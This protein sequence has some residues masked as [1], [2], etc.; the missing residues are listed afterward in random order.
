[1]SRR[2]RISVEDIQAEAEEPQAQA[3]GSFR[4][5][6]FHG[7]QLRLESFS[8]QTRNPFFWKS[9]DSVPLSPETK[10]QAGKK[11]KTR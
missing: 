11:M 9:G 3:R 2:L 4:R 5:V 1:M 6:S 7:K 10:T 8:L